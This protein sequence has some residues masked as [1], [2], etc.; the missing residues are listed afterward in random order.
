MNR[1]CSRC[2]VRGDHMIWCPK[3]LV[4]DMNSAASSSCDTAAPEVIEMSVDEALG[5]AERRE[6]IDGLTALNV[7]RAE[8]RRLRAAVERVKALDR[9]D[10][11]DEYMA[12]W[13]DGDWIDRADVLRILEG[14]D[15]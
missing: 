11:K 9:Y 10:C 7:L 6:P 8:V 14:T 2:G 12:L 1:K 3:R 15:G 4:L 13:P 5:L